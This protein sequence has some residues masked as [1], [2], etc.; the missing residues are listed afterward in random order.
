MKNI[1][2]IIGLILMVFALGACEDYLKEAALPIDRPGGDDFYDTPEKVKSGVIGC[3]NQMYSIYDRTQQPKV[4]LNV[5]D[6][7]KYNEN[8]DALGNWSLQRNNSP[9]NIWARNFT[10]VSRTNILIASIEKG[11]PDYINDS[12]IARY[13]GDA[14]MLRAWAYMNLVVC[15]GDL[16]KLT[17]Q[18]NNFEES[19]DVSRRPADEIWTDIILPDLEF[20]AANCWKRSEIEAR[21]ELGMITQGAAKLYLA[22]AYLFRGMYE[23]AEAQA[24]GVISSGEYAWIDD[25]ASLFGG[26]DNHSASIFE[27]QHKYPDQ[28]NYYTRMLPFALQQASGMQLP[29]TITRPTD[30][31]VFTMLESGEDVRYTATCDTGM[32]D[33]IDSVYVRCNYWKKYFDTSVQGT[34]MTSGWNVNFLRLADAYHLAAEA[35]VQQDKFSEA[36]VHLNMTRERAQV[37]LYDVADFTDKNTALDLYLHERRM[38]FAGEFK[39]WRDLKRTGKAIEVISAYLG[40]QVEEFRLV[41][42]IPSSEIAINPE[43]MVQNPGY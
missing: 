30:S 20:A 39:R 25:Y 19:V 6:D 36:V 23:Q 21:G 11:F 38:E 27:L 18:L 28:I 43:G 35:E 3:M 16:P 22:E 32:F 26:N 5:T 12:E 9:E 17:E 14:K 8:E 42:P 7:G 13:M 34:D 33:N 24:E 15:F 31:L 29:Q 1:K 41:W 40:R 10:L 4:Y 2:Y 37:P